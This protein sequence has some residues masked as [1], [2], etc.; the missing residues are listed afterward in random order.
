MCLPASMSPS[1][2]D[3][4]LFMRTFLAGLNLLAVDVLER[5]MVPHNN[6]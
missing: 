3:V 4:P 5:G 1:S 6:M 2:I